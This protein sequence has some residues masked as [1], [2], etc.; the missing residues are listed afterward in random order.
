MKQNLIFVLFPTLL[1]FTECSLNSNIYS[2]NGYFEA[3]FSDEPA[4]FV[5]K[6]F[7]FGKMAYY[8]SPFIEDSTIEGKY[9]NEI[10]FRGIYLKIK[11]REEME[12]DKYLSSFIKGFADTRNYKI[13]EMDMIKHNKIDALIYKMEGTEVGINC[14]FRGICALKEN[15]ICL[16]DIE[17]CG[18]ADGTI[19]MKLF[20]DYVK[21]FTIY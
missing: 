8:F 10:S 13:I 19:S 3:Y 5:E 6:E 20:E 1:L 21:Y 11:E 15:I 14:Q 7:D 17:E 18:D 12:I 16:W 4:L 9:I 2:V